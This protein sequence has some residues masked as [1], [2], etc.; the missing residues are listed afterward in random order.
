MRSI[1]PCPCS[2]ARQGAPDV[3][4]QGPVCQTDLD[5]VPEA[6]VAVVEAP[7]E[8]EQIEADV[9]RERLLEEARG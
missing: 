6:P 5:A 2:A 3:E 4:M 1:P 7:P 9:E 8:P